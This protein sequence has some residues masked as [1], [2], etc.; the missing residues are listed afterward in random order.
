MI[1]HLP[2][3]LNTKLDYKRIKLMKGMTV[4]LEEE[5]QKSEAN[6]SYL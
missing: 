2:D 3:E 1:K 4:V 6:L 5:V